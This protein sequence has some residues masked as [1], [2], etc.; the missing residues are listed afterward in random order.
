MYRQCTCRLCPLIRTHTYIHIQTVHMQAMPTQA[1]R[2]HQQFEE[3][4]VCL[5]VCVY[6]RL[7][8]CMYVC[9]HVCMCVCVCVCVCVSILC[10]SCDKKLFFIFSYVFTT[11]AHSLGRNVYMYVYVYTYICSISAPA[12]RSHIL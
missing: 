1:E 4:K 7:C 5:C 2:L 12:F 6:A 3:K 9:M 11:G 10:L 8:V